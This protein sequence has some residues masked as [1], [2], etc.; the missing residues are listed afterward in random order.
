[1]TAIPVD[2][3]SFSAYRLPA[4][5]GRHEPA[6]FLS[7]AHWF[8]AEKF[9]AFQP[10]LFAQIML[11]PTVKEARK[12]AD[13]NRQHWRGDWLGVR[14]RALAC[15][16]VY[17]SAADPDKQR[18]LGQPEQIARELAT[19]GFP[20]RFTL[21]VAME[22]CRI[23]N[24]P[25]MAFFGAAAAPHDVVGRRINLV[26]K[27][28]ERAWRLLH[29]QGRHG[30]WKVH[31]WCVSQYIPIVY[32]GA[33]DERVTDSAVTKLRGLCQ[34]AIVFEARGGKAMDSTLRVMRAHKLPIELDLY[35]VD[36]S[37]TITE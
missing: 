26:H 23:R 11:C 30:C 18:W 2:Q 31:D 36:A 13:R 14:L 32:A 29:W 3:L 15:G 24:A 19:L 27:K 4:A 8:E 1:M 17:A 37:G 25:V 33:H 10:E 21:G 22:Y 16:L 7:L 9:R 34:T 12:L 6:A 20:E 35:K 28:N 5:G